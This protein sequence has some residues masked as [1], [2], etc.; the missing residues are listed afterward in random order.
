MFKYNKEIVKNAVHY[1]TTMN[2]IIEGE[3]IITNQDG[4]IIEKSNWKN[5]VK[6]GL[7]IEYQKT[8]NYFANDQSISHRRQTFYK[9]GKKH[10]NEFFYFVDGN[11][12]AIGTWEMGVLVQGLIYRRG[13]NMVLMEKSNYLTKTGEEYYEDG[14]TVRC[15]FSFKDDPLDRQCKYYKKDGSEMTHNESMAFLGWSRCDKCGKYGLCEHLY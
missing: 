14:C 9:N 13:E 2:G 1:Y 10:G 5:G 7:E 4:T 3:E 8:G 6:D 15:R 11:I 12:D